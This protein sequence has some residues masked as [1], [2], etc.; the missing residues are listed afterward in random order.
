MQL[1]ALLAT[2]KPVLLDFSAEWCGP[3]RLLKP[4]LNQLQAEYGDALDVHLIDVEAQP[5]LAEQFKI[6]SMPTLLLFKNGELHWRHVGLL[7]LAE[8]KKAVTA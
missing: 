1:S 6:R 7:S 4:V 3:C 2:D 5:E 8:L